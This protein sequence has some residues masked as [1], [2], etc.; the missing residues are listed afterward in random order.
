[1][2]NNKIDYILERKDLSG[3]L[4]DIWTDLEDINRQLGIPRDSIRM[5]RINGVPCHGYW[6]EKVPCSQLQIL[7]SKIN[8]QEIPLS[9]DL[10]LESSMNFEI[11]L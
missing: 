7:E 1:M 3:K 6:F 2:F 5:A 4:L 10:I 9:E 8:N 11:E